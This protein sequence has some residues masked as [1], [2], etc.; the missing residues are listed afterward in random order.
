V[1]DIDFN[2]LFAPALKR[3]FCM[4]AAGQQPEQVTTGIVQALQQLHRR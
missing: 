3:V 4:G 1:R 2:V